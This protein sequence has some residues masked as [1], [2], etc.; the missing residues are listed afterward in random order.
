MDVHGLDWDFK[1][2]R[3]ALV[4]VSPNLNSVGGKTLVNLIAGRFKGLVHPVNS[5]YE[6]VSG[7]QCFPSIRSLPKVPDLG[8]ICSPAQSVPDAVRECGEAG[9]RGILIQSAGFRESGSLGLA[10]EKE[11]HALV[12]YFTRACG[13]WGQTAWE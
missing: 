10:L 12:E 4:G 2:N 6:S 13:F 9:V 7:V 11:I 3:I 8:I 1:P 5:A